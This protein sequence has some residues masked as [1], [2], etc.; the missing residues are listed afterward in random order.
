MTSEARDVTGEALPQFRRL[1]EG[2]IHAAEAVAVAFLA[3]DVVVLIWSVTAR[4][5][6][7]S[8]LVWAE[9]AASLC[10]LWLGWP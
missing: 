8:P 3:V 6:F 10:F 2:L 7:N 9:E 1:R 5:V 4:Y